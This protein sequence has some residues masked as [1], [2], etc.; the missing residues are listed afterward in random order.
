MG[1]WDGCVFILFL[2]NRSYFIFCRVRPPDM[3][4]AS[5]LT[6]TC[7]KCCAQPLGWWGQG[8]PFFARAYHLLAIQ[9]LLGQDGGQPAKHMPTSINKSILGHLDTVSS[10]DLPYFKCSS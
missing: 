5:V 9:Q 7:R 1:P 6:T 2:R 4:I 3:Q 10:R 8:G